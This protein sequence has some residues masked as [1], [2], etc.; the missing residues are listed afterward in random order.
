[1]DKNLLVKKLIIIFSVI[2]VIIA[3]AVTVALVSGN[4]RTPAL[5]DPDGVFYQRTDDSG[6]VIYTITNQELYDEIKSNDGLTQLLYSVDAYLLQDY[7]AALTDEQIANKLLDLKYGTH[8]QSEIDDLSADD[9]ASMEATFHQNMVLAGYG[10]SEAEAEEYVSLIL[11]RIEYARYALEIGDDI[12]DTAIGT[13]YGSKWFDDIKAIKIRFTSSSDVKDVMRKNNLLTYSSTTIRSYLGFVYVSEGLV[14]KY[15]TSNPTKIV[16]VYKTVSPFYM[17][18]NQNLLNLSGTIVYTKGTDIYTDATANE[19]HLDVDGNLL[20]ASD[21]IVVSKDLIFT[22]STLATAYQQANTIYYTLTKVDP[23]NADEPAAV[24]DGNGDTV[25]TIDKDNKIW[26]GGVDVTSTCGLTV[27]KVYKD[28]SQVNATTENNSAEMTNEEVLAAFIKMYNYVYGDYRDAIPEAWTAADLIA[29]ENEYLTHNFEDTY[30][31]SSSLAT[32]MF[33]TLDINYEEDAIPYSPVGKTYNG[34]KDTSV[35]LIYKLSQPEKVNVFQRM[36][37]YVK[38][39]VE[40]VIPEQTTANITLP[41]KGWYS[42]TITWS[43]SSNSTVLTTAGVVTRPDADTTVTLT[44]KIV[45]NGITR[46]G[47]TVDVKVLGTASSESTS[48]IG[49]VSETQVTV[50]TILNDAVLYKAVKDKL[51]QDKLDDTTNSAK[52]INAKLAAMRAECGFEIYDYYLGIDY[53]GVASDYELNRKGSKKL[54]ATL[55]GR[56]GYRGAE[57]VTE[58]TEITADDL[59]EYCMTKNVALYTLYT[60]Q[61][62]EMVYSQYFLSAFG[63]QTDIRKNKSDKM[64]DMLNSVTSVKSQYSQYHDL[65]MSNY[66]MY[67]YYLAQFDYDTFADYAYSVYGTKSEYELLQYFVEGAIQPFIVNEAISEYDLLALFTAAIQERYDNYFSLYVTHL[68]LYVDFNEDGNPDDFN[69]YKAQ[70]QDEGTYD[71][72]LQRMNAFETAI[73]NYLDDTEAD[74]DFDSLLSDYRAATRDDATWGAFKQYGFC[75]M[76]ETLNQTDDSDVE[77]SM[78]YNGTYGVKDTYVPEFVDALKAIYEEYRLDQNKTLAEL[79]GSTL[80]PTEYGLHLLLVK[81]GDYFDQYSAAFTEADPANKVYSE[82]SENANALP[83]AEQI[84]LYAK[85]YFYSVVYDLTDEQVESKYGITVP[86]LPASVNSAL[87]FYAGDLIES[88]YVVG[89][90]NVRT[91]DLIVQGNWTA[92]P[93]TTLTDAQLKA[94][95]A[96]VRSVYYDALFADYQN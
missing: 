78:E 47:L 25:Y 30:A 28:I 42:S 74:N 23:F 17:D 70:L 2:L 56:I 91:A 67:S 68:L 13:E 34:S 82:G 32:Y 66:A 27:N 5:S 65:L 16:E 62:K 55:T 73:L 93:Y 96:E 58:D 84:A 26:E 4:T 39:N 8:V 80:F 63:E 31:I 11:A 72:F 79:R 38:A 15:N 1:M 87:K 88:L 35:Y 51:I 36:I 95:L 86:N 75:L 59:L 14:E 57:G 77:H 53:Q 64:Q 21:V 94:M 7:L 48:E 9:K 81:K 60:I 71:V 22:D 44:Y 19:F 52:T 29:S 3:S 18:A 85:Y 50:E 24:K 33:S 41:T 10:D 43:A 20:N 61:F 40:L 45:C 69:D 83:S 49:T 12:T 46:S 54:L 76:T 89:L 92:T 90:V 37:D 6:N